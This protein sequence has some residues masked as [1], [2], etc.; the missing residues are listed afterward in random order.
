M[1]KYE[2]FSIAYKVLDIRMH[3]QVVTLMRMCK[4]MCRGSN[5]VGLIGANWIIIIITS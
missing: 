1:S 3:V 2:Y 4:A 5:V